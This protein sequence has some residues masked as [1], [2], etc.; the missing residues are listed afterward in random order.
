MTPTVL[1]I[2]FT[3]LK[4]DPRVHRKIEAL[5]TNHAAIAA[6]AGDL[7]LP[8][9]R[10]IRWEYRQRSISE[11][12]NAAVA[13]LLRRHESYYWKLA[14]VD[15]LDNKLEGFR[16]DSVIS[17]NIESLPLALKV[18]RELPVIIDAHEYSPLEFEDHRIWR[19]FFGHCKDDICRWR[20][21]SLPC[22]KGLQIA[23]HNQSMLPPSST[24]AH[25]GK[26]RREAPGSCV[27][28]A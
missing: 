28:C 11:E 8:G 27:I 26:H 13:F 21:Q 14:H 18:A 5:R 4:R 12:I 20:R 10:F 23:T 22:A 16:F 15:E 1:L 6:S 3:D 2:S 24:D 19:V 25:C 9:V 7:E 17:D